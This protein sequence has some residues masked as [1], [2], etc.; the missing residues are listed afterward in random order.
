MKKLFVPTKCVSLLLCFALLLSFTLLISSCGSKSVKS[1]SGFNEIGT[2]ITADKA[3]NKQPWVVTE[4]G[5]EEGNYAIAQ[6][7]VASDEV[8]KLN[9][10]IH[11]K[12]AG[13]NGDRRLKLSY[14]VGKKGAL[15]SVLFESVCGNRQ[16][17]YDAY[18]VDLSS[19]KPTESGAIAALYGYSKK[20]Y[21]K[22]LKSAVATEFLKEYGSFK[23][24]SPS[25]DE[26]LLKSTQEDYLKRAVPFANEEGKLSAVVVLFGMDGEEHSAT[27]LLEE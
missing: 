17:K 14:T 9:E 5:Y 3:D 7:N 20:E 19:G 25:Y 8:Q 26:A 18:S 24:K 16:K 22:A 10:Q 6:F 23:D 13:E 12:F 11:E 2:E 15:C 4:E 21:T 1:S 27:V